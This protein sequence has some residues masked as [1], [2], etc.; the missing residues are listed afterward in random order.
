M[1][2]LPARIIDAHCHIAAAEHIP[3]SFV[4]GSVSNVVA[5]LTAQGIPATVDKLT[6]IFLEK[7]RDPL[8]DDLVKEMDQ[9]GI[10]KAFLLAADFSYALRDCP[11]TIEESYLRHRD[12]LKRHPDRFEV[13]GGM[14]PRWGRDGLD[15]FERSLREFGFRGFKL[16]PP[17][18][19]APSDPSLFPFYEICAHYRVPVTVH[20]G[21]TSPAL[22]F[23]PTY[24]FLLDEAARRFPSVNFI[25]AHGAVSFTEEC[26]MLCAFRP[27]LF[28]DISAF[29][30]ALRRDGSAA[31]VKAAVAKGINHKILFGTDWPVFRLQGDQ[32]AFVE[33]VCGENGPLAD[34]SDADR[35]MILHGNAER[36]LAEARCPSAPVS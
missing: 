13:F 2:P 34:L 10:A 36:L 4:T 7:M 20:I 26:A 5:V 23:T 19:F 35:T 29:Q 25:M 30:S 9:A 8:C 11:L 28:M 15:L 21:P 3:R 24:P 1:D 31:V 14:D 18:G 6:A 32:K 17:T 27:N 16:Y 33:A 12:V 22:S